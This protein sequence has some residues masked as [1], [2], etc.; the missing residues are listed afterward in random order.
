MLTIKGYERI[1]KTT[2]RVAIRVICAYKTVLHATAGLLAGIHLP[3][4]LANDRNQRHKELRRI[5]SDRRVM[6]LPG[7]KE[8][9]RRRCQRDG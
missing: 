1:E 6:I 8:W 3:E 9:V 5:D 7:T 2:R 4:I